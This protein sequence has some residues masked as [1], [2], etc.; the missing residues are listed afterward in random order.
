MLLAHQS[1]LKDSDIKKHYL[2]ISSDGD[3]PPLGPWIVENLLPNVSD[4]DPNIWSSSR[5]GKNFYY[6]NAGYVVIGYLVEQIS[7]Q[8][9]DQYCKEHIFT[10][11]DMMNTS[12][13][14]SDLNIDN[15]AVPYV[16]VRYHP[17]LFSGAEWLFDKGK[18]VSLPY[19]STGAYYPAGGL[20]TSVNDLSHFLIAHINGGV[21]NGVRILNEST[22]DLMHTVQYPS[23][24]RNLGGSRWG[25]GWQI[26]EGFGKTTKLG[27]GGDGLASHANMMFLKD[28]KVGVIYFTNRALTG[29][30]S[31][32]FI[33]MF[34]LEKV[35]FKKANEFR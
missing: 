21:Y 24:P 4:Y 19:G 31:A 16:R 12:F 13:A 11:L 30:F 33:R 10:P 28:K 14:L 23:D 9:F 25:L 15:V 26:K 18:Y 2:N 7:N 1:S 17:R 35:L 27:H 32:F 20:R 22:I 6:A 8:S 3:T 29:D 5:P 34:I